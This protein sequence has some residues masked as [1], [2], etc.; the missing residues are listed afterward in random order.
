MGLSGVREEEAKSS[1]NGAPGDSERERGKKR[2]RENNMWGREENF[3]PS[4][5]YRAH[6][7]Q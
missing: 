4:I 3:L 7:I 6:L 1:T 5:I 2:E